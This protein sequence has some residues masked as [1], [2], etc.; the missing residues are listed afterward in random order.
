MATNI[1]RL[2]DRQIRNASKPLSDGGNL[3]VYP[4]GNYR[5]WIFR[6]MIQGRA[7][8]MGLGAYPDVSLV[9]ARKAAAKYRDILKSGVDPID[10]RDTQA[11]AAA[12]AAAGVPTFTQVAAR[13]I[14]AHRR[15]W[16]NPKHARQWCATLKTYARPII[17]AKPV[18]QIVTDDVLKV[19]SGIWNT[20][21][22]TAKRVQGRLENVLDF[23]AAHKW[24]DQSNPAR[25]R[26]H[27]DKLLP[28]PS[29]VATVAHHPAM[30]Y[31]A[32]PAFMLELAGKPG[33]SAL[34]LRF[35]ILTACRTGEVVGATWSEIDMGA[36]VWTIPAERMKAKREHRVPLSAAA[37][38]VLA[39]LPR[40]DGNP[41]LFPG[42]RYGRPIST[43]AMLMQMR[44]MG[45][46]VGGDRGDC[47]PHGFRSAFR[48][49]SG[50]VSTFP[51]DVCEMA[52]A[53]TIQDKV[54]AAYRRGDLMTKRAAMMEQWGEW[55]SRPAP[56]VAEITQAKARH[57]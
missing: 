40:V 49:W 44:G 10:Y 24:R 23:A 4:K 28:R 16:S 30:E 48:D 46:R 33:V 1:H 53:H 43:M 52:L 19:L 32:V 20:K 11:Q 3:W 56:V 15:G 34:A 13:F 54:E 25:W 9:T 35:L 7:R 17:G 37:L 39:A 5:G 12:L 18:D 27:L 51:R 21:T 8:E 41:Y 29:R 22:E 2:T 45:Y 14:R 36:A 57:A 38:A 6:Y 31:T 50:E 42:A 26:G 55:C 47:V